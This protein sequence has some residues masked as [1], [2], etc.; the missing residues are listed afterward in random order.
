MWKKKLV[1]FLNILF[2]FCAREVL[3]ADAFVM[4]SHPLSVE[5]GKKI[6]KNGGG[7]ADAAVAMALTLAV[8]QPERSGL[9]GGGVILYRDHSRNE[10]V[11]VDYLEACSNSHFKSIAQTENGGET[12]RT[13]L[14]QGYGLVGVPGFMMG[15]GKF[16]ERFGRLEWHKLFADALSL[17][18]E[19]VELDQ[20]VLVS[21]QEAIKSWPD[22]DILRQS[23]SGLS[24]KNRVWRQPEL[25]ETL[26]TLSEKGWQDF[27]TGDLSQKLLAEFKTNGSTLEKDDLTFY[28]VRFVKAAE[29]YHRDLRI[30]GADRPVLS[31]LF[32]EHIIKAFAGQDWKDQPTQKNIMEHGVKDFFSKQHLNRHKPSAN[33]EP[34]AFILVRDAQGNLAIMINT[35]HQLWGSARTLAGLGFLPNAALIHPVFGELPDSGG[36]AGDLL[37]KKRPVSFLM[38]LLIQRG[39]EDWALLATT[40]TAGP[41]LALQI[42][43][44]VYFEGTKLKT[45]ERASYSFFL[46]DLLRRVEQKYTAVSDRPEAVFI[47]MAGG[48]AQKLILPKGTMGFA[49]VK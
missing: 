6:L 20:D 41:Q 32:L 23:V 8:V 48:R 24:R 40:S 42:L 3:A 26:L 17:A 18:K 5:T 10:T 21:Y 15:L 12:T 16:S 25:H 49:G 11:F 30:Y 33:G 7:A 14:E 39:F 2:F 13:D 27:Y 35:L 1:L 4:S 34:A 38:P 9:G 43:A 28:G 45:V 46:P 37:L 47:R 31:G 29:F 44:P 36:V 19:G 22:A